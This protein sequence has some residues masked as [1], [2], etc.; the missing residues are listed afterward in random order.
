[1]LKSLGNS[2]KRIGKTLFPSKTNKSERIIVQ[3]NSSQQ[4]Q[5]NEEFKEAMNEVSKSVNQIGLTTEEVHSTLKLFNENNTVNVAEFQIESPFEEEIEKLFA[6][7]PQ[8]GKESTAVV[9]KFPQFDIKDVKVYYGDL[10]IQEMKELKLID[11]KTMYHTRPI[12][13]IVPG[14]SNFNRKLYW[15]KK[16]SQRK[17]GL[18]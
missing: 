15:R 12:V 9:S 6:D 16:K 13:D 4:T 3:H 1:M 18:K 11:E 2:I 14:K 5:I 8:L 7:E 17:R 10:E